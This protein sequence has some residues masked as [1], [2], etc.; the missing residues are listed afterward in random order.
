M[1]VSSI[2]AFSDP[3]E[4]AKSVRTTEMSAFVATRGEFA[5]R[6]TRIDLHHLWLQRSWTSLPLITHSVLH[7][8]RRPVYFLADADQAQGFYCGTPMSAGDIVFYSLG[9]ES[10]RRTPA[11]RTWATM[12]LTP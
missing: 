2:R 11:N 10:H 6:L 12:S 4:Y 9:T 8:S 3:Y 1:S 5:A 7:K